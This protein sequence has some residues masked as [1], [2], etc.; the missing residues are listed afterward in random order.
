[1]DKIQRCKNTG[2][3]TAS[4]LEELK[5][6]AEEVRQLA[7]ITFYTEKARNGFVFQLNLTSLNIYQDFLKC[8]WIFLEDKK[9]H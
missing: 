6:N 3:L 9:L 7:R 4:K 8:F 1:M 2:R 5:T